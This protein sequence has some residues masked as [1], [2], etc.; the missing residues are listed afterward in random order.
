[1]D[2]ITFADFA[3]V[4][5][6]IGEIVTAEVP[7]GSERVIKMTVDFG[8]DKRTIF[9]GIKQ[10]FKPVE[11][12]GKKMPFILNIPPKKMGEMGESQGMI[13]AVDVVEDGVHKPVFLIPEMS[14]PNGSQLK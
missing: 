11:L 9:A 1:M 14:V 12:V 5:M 8:E 4:E 7:E 3:K 6:K 13:L 2:E 10:W